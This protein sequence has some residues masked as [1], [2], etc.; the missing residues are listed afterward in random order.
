MKYFIPS[1]SR[2]PII[3][4]LG[5]F[6]LMIGFINIL[7]K[8]SIGILLSIS[9][10]VLIIFMITGWL[11]HVINENL[12]GLHNQKMDVSYRWGMFW[13]I[14]SEAAFF[15]I[16]FGAL[17]YSRFY[18]VPALA[19]LVS[20]PETG[21]LLWPHFKA[22]WPLLINPNAQQFPGP[23]Q[24]METW[25]IPAVNTFILLSSAAA[26]T[27]GQW[28]LQKNRR[29]QMML[30]V[31]LTILLGLL[32]ISLQAHEYILAYTHYNLTLHSGIYGTTFF[33]LTGF[34]G[35]HVCIGLTMLSVIWVR[36]FKGHFRPQHHFGFEAVSWYWHFVDVIWLMLFVFVYWL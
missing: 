28:G 1:P 31:S 14:A 12:N 36:C 6:F 29:L 25:G 34:H 15:G 19:G 7:H 8:N 30:G 10:I 24:V 22:A 35:L 3:G 2:W 18:A 20:N 16:F 33:M 27:W 11:T 21:I 26:I 13:F 23:T 5:L 32:F 17:F 9:G 4:S